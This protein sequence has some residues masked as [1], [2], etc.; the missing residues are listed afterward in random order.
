MRTSSLLLLGW[1]LAFAPPVVAQERG[2]DE[3]LDLT[4]K[5]LIV[6]LQDRSTHNLQDTGVRTI[7]GRAFLMGKP[8]DLNSQGKQKDKEESLVLFPVDR[9]QEITLF[10]SLEALQARYRPSPDYELRRAKAQIDHVIGEIQT[11]QEALARWKVEIAMLEESLARADEKQKP[12]LEKRLKSGRS[13]FNSLK[14]E[15]GERVEVKGLS[16]RT[17]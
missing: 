5:V 15:L 6:I 10:K 4:G 9:I 3:K 14:K 1:L 13:D 7:G 12:A 17:S 11:R 2:R 16:S 8:I